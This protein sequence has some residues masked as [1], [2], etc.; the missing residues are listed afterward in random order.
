MKNSIKLFLIFIFSGIYVTITY[1]NYWIYYGTNKNYAKTLYSKYD[2]IIMQDYNYHLFSKY[3]GKKICYL[4]VWEFDG[5]NESL[6]SL[7]LSWSKIWENKNW[8]SSI[9][10]MWNQKWI[11]YVLQKQTDL[12]ILGCDGLFL[13]T[14]WQDGYE[15]EA[16]DLVKIIKNNWKE[17]YIIVNNWHNIMYDIVDY[18]DGYMF[19]NFWSY[20]TIIWT[21]DADWYIQLAREYEILAKKN[22]K[23]IYTLIYW[24]PNKN[25]KLKKWWLQVKK[26]CSQYHFEFIFSNSNI[27]KIY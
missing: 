18:I 16:I 2:L 6:I 9:M 22:N 27:D 20:G 17:S 14:I 23:K 25:L 1:W 19:E 15:K 4:S 10:D 7:G 24:N 26:I 12:K 3:N 11:D 13:D 5:N 8:E 21:T